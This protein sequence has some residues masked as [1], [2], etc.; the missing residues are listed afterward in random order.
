MLSQMSDLSGEYLLRGD[1]AASLLL[2]SL[3]GGSVGD[4]GLCGQLRVLPGLGVQRVLDGGWRVSHSC[5][6]R[7]YFIL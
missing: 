2:G 6:N 3:G 4:L 1:D 7:V 5:M